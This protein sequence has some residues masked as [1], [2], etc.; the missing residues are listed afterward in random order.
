MVAELE[1]SISPHLYVKTANDLLWS[2]VTIPW[3]VF[4]CF[5]EEHIMYDTIACTAYLTGIGNLHY[6]MAEQMLVRHSI[7]QSVAILH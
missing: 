6:L 4:V 3:K 7:Q 1:Y 5:V 2:V